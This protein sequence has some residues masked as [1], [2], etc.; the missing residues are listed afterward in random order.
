MPTLRELQVAWFEADAEYAKAL[1]AEYGADACNKRYQRKH[2]SPIV[3]AAREKFRYCNKAWI[4]EW[5]RLQYER[6][7]TVAAL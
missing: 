5:E 7:A 6:I 3:Q 2:Q 4:E 1:V